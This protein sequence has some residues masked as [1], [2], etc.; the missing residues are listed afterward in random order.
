MVQF[1]GSMPYEPEPIDMDGMESWTQRR[2]TPRLD[3]AVE[4]LKDILADGPVKSEDILNMAAEAGLAIDTLRRAKDE[5]HVSVYKVGNG[6]NSHWF[7][8]LPI[9]G[10]LSGNVEDAAEVKENR[11]LQITGETS[12][13]NR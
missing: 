12:D 5:L 11:I 8:A 2:P 3:E 9:A 7:W 1:S 10:E 6:E 4:W 13:D